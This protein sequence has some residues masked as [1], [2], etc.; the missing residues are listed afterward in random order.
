L[1]ATCYMGLIALG[2]V[3]I[4]SYGGYQVFVGTLTVGGLVA[5]YS[6]LGRLF[7]PLNVA[8]DIYSRLNRLR[9]SIRRILGILEQIPGV[10]NQPNCVCLSSRVRGS[11]LI[12]DVCFSY[13]ISG[14]CVLEQLNL[15]IKPGEKVALVGASGSGKSTVT[16]LIARLYDVGRGTICIDDLDV[17]TIDLNSLR[18]AICYVMQETI[19]FDRSLKEN[20]MLGNPEATEEEL[21]RAIAMTD[22]EPLL[23]RLPD[24][25]NTPLGPRGNT[26]SGG[27]RQRLALARA[28]LQSPS[29]LILDESTSALD[30]PTEQNILSNLSQHFRHQTMIVVSHRLSALTWVDRIIVLNQGRIE[31][32]G[33]HDYL[34][35]RGGLYARLYNTPLSS[36]GLSASSPSAMA[37]S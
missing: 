18:T 15:Q 5:F 11:V 32:Q 26:L 3:G 37:R 22:L 1:F 25:W 13:R 16:K 7:D 31:D 24:G 9:S 10:A 28:V 29:L 27:E 21:T 14:S 20:L 17:R 8:V 36:N 30:A 23:Q 12:S 6:Y 33:T 19:L 4:L 2:T 34:L 35:R